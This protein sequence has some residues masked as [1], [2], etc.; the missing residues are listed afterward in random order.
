MKNDIGYAQNCDSNICRGARERDEGAR[1]WSSPIL[2]SYA[3]AVT[4]PLAD[5]AALKL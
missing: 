3:D 4:S 5:V 1:R 2:R